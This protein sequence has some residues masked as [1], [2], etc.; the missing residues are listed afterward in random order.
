MYMVQ[1]LAPYLIVQAGN[2]AVPRHFVIRWPEHGHR[3]KS[4]SYATFN[5][6]KRVEKKQDQCKWHTPLVNV[7]L[8]N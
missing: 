8:H 7:A 4:R 6:L 1:G 3:F 5:V 2:Q